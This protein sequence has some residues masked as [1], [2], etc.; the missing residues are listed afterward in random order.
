MS[1]AAASTPAPEH[2]RDPRRSSSTYRYIGNKTWMRDH[3]IALFEELAPPGGRIA[4][5]M[6]GT[7]SVA[8]AARAAGFRVHASDLMTYASHHARVRLLL[9]EAPSFRRLGRGGYEAAL[10]RLE[11]AIPVEGYLH[12]EFSPDGVPDNGVAPRQYFS[13]QNAAKLDGIRRDI[14]DWSS[15]GLLSP[16]EHALLR[17]D[18]V[19]AANRIANIAGTYGHFRSKWNAQALRPLQLTATAFEPGPVRGHRV[20]QGRVEDIARRIDVDVCYLDPPYTKRQY[21]ANYHVLE[22]LARGDEPDAVGVS[23]LRPWRDQYSDFCSK[24]R[25][26]SSFRVVAQHARFSHLVVSYSEDGL[27][28]V[29]EMFELLGEFGEVE[30]RTIPGRRFRSN[31]SKLPAAIDEYL[32]IVAR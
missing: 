13:A 5:P 26:R 22:T 7:A 28:A 12:R 29:P 2:E 11:D 17:H 16:I 3:L 1:T 6:C 21:A 27:L 31:Q 10:A 25:I 15:Q 19:L 4:D 9:D 18:L 14:A 23:G 20:D 30:L 8:A 24:L 32:F